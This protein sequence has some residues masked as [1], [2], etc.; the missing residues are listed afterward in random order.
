[1]DPVTLSILA[2][3]TLSAL[4]IYQEGQ[5]RAESLLEDARNK[6]LQS[7]EI[8][9]RANQNT[10]IYKK[11]ANEVMSQQIATYAKSGVDVSTGAPLDALSESVDVMVSEINNIRREAA[12]EASQ[13]MKES[14]SREKLA[15]Q[16]D[17]ASKLSILASGL[18][19]GGEY[20]A[21]SS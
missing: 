14:K 21:K 1:M 5:D 4:A 10:E 3:T 7:I 16:M 8:L 20:Y 19:A 17:T 15:G 11:K 13:V 9:N 18:K 2:G 6:R 12:F